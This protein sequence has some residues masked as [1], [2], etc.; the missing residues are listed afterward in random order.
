MPTPEK[1]TLSPSPIDNSLAV[2]YDAGTGE[3]M[4]FAPLFEGGLAAQPF[5]IVSGAFSYGSSILPWQRST[6]DFVRSA[7]GVD[8]ES[9]VVYI[10]SDD[11]NVYRFEH[12]SGF[13]LAG[14][15]LASGPVLSSPLIVGGYLFVIDY[16]GR[17]TALAP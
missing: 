1:L 13:S 11:G 4:I 16:T 10:G 3:G 14:T 7:P 8:L 9:G 6:N 2:S 15:F 12:D 17:I 5:S